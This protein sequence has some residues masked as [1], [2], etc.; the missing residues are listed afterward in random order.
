M[1]SNS[2]PGRVDRFLQSLLIGNDAA[3]DAVLK[4]SDDAGL[5]QIAVAPLQGAFL[6][7]LAAA[8][9]AKRILEI[10]A[11][12]GYSTIWLARALPADGGVVKTL[13]IDPTS[14]ATVRAN[15]AA[16]GFAERIEAI[17]GP[18]AKSLDAMI[19]AGEAPFDFVFIDA[20]KPGY[21]A[22]LDRSI[23]LTRPG[24]LIVA[25]NVVWEGEVAN[26]KCA[27]PRVAGVR[28]Y[29]EKAGAVLRL[30]TTVIQTV[31][32]K[33]HDGFAFSLVL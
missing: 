25:D 9:G 14:V 8:M 13:D 28:A 20:D 27:D 30:K 26:R 33:G 5:S 17:E 31:G 15:A 16:A 21:P 23:A 29:L 3:M 12:G 2:K 6:S 24:S 1:K 22:C 18:A 7:I 10:G 11:L 32:A 4:R 19:K